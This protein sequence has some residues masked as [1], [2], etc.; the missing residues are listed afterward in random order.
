MSQLPLDPAYEF[1][2]EEGLA[3]EAAE[4]RGSHEKF[5][6]VAERQLKRARVLHLIEQKRLLT[7]F[8]AERWR[9]GRN[10]SARIHIIRLHLLY[11]RYAAGTLG[12]G[13]SATDQEDEDSE[14]SS[15]A[16]GTPTRILS[17]NDKLLIWWNGF[18]NG[19]WSGTRTRE[20]LLEGREAKAEGLGCLFSFVGVIAFL[21]VGFGL[22]FALGDEDARASAQAALIVL[23]LVTGAVLVLGYLAFNYKPSP[24]ASLSGSGIVVRE[25]SDRDKFERDAQRLAAQGYR[26]VS[27]TDRQQRA[28]VVR[29]ATIGFGAL[30]WKPKSHLVVTYEAR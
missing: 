15:E 11:T 25:Y 14:D 20:A 17:R 24:E 8:L 3:A 29:M 21:V 7:R 5:A 28:G 16:N 27:V 1:L 12:A 26:V 9:D 2:K 18:M 30:I 4:I 10:E 22:W 6:G 23:G 13:F 19:R